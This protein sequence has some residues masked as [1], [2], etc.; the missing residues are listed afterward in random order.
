MMDCCQDAVSIQSQR[1]NDL[2]SILANLPSYLQDQT[3]SQ[4]PT[5]KL[6]VA[7]DLPRYAGYLPTYWPG[8]NI[9]GEVKIHLDLPI[10]VTHLRVALFG[11]VQVYGNHPGH[12][13]TNGL[14]DYKKNEQLV[15]TGL[16]IIRKS[17]VISTAEQRDTVCFNDSDIHF[18]TGQLPQD[19]RHWRLLS[20]RDRSD[21]EGQH[22]TA[23]V[24]SMHSSLH[25][26]GMSSSSSPPEGRAKKRS[27][28]T[29]EDKQMEKL[30]RRVAAIDHAANISNGVFYLDQSI[31]STNSSRNE[32]SNSSK[33]NSFPLGAN[34]HQIRFAVRVPTS[35]RL[36]GTFDHP[37]FPIG[38]RV[39]CIMKCKS[40][41]GG[42]DR[43]MICYAT[44]K[45][46]LEPY[47]DVNSLT[48]STPIQTSSK[49]LY[50]QKDNG[51]ITG[52]YTYALSS[53]S[54]L[55]QWMY[56]LAQWK[57]QKQSRVSPFS[58]YLQAHLELPKQAFGRSQYIPLKLKLANFASTHF[59]VSDIKITLELIRRINMTCSVSE[60]MESILVQ[61]ATVLFKGSGED[62]QQPVTDDIVFFKHAS[63]CFDLS[64]VI[65][66]P[67]DC[68]CSIFSE[69]T[70]DVFTL[71][72]DVNVR[73]DV[74]GLTQ[75]ME[76][77]PNG[78]EEE[79]GVTYVATDKHILEN[80][81]QV[82]LP[83]EAYQ[84]KLKTYTFHL[85]PL[86]VIVG[87]IG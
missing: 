71:G 5:P 72:Y 40:S 66:I 49:I 44:V 33:N 63:L 59:K 81:A 36:S 21:A 67:D 39:V 28:K 38:Y 79:E 69:S 74:T 82:S 51:L 1:Y 19:E 42:D 73:L 46:R 56:R 70:K 86:T 14:F 55:T 75:K 12:P 58:S 34:T 31:L 80:A 22:Q 60:E 8:Q 10:Q 77:T 2:E 83:K 9:T 54:T 30:I 11:N 50:V 16:R 47:I 64:K 62:P 24:G 23:A 65:K 85:D 68:V 52:V 78:E 41:N 61:L 15:N 43:D 76:A 18:E 20:C 29:L 13:M 7:L 25:Q 26:Q 35:H 53:S 4:Q 45:L 48:F 87:N 84:H 57:H 17:P 6:T 37:H 27:N 32:E 3:S